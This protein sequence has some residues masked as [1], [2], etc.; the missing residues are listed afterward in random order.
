M[1]GNDRETDMTAIVSAISRALL[2]TTGVDSS[3]LF[4]ALACLFCFS[5]RANADLALDFGDLTL[6]PAAWGT[7]NE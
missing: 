4:A 1:A 3:P 6:P 5:W 7:F 2:S